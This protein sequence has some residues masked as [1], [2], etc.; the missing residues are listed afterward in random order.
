MLLRMSVRSCEQ[1]NNNPEP[2]AY[3]VTDA[4]IGSG[5]CLPTLKAKKEAA[6]SFSELLL[7]R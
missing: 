3:V 5:L 7:A 4:A 1:F 2:I 6:T